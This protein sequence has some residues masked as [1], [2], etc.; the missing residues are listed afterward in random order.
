MASTKIRGITIEL[1]A[2]T[3]GLTKAL[4]NT[5]KE[6][7]ST[8][9]QLKDVERLLKLDP[10]NTE[11]LEQK[12]RLLGQSVEQTRDKL[13]ALKEAQKQVA[14][15]L[16]RTGEGQEQYD[17]L[18][19]EIIQTEA[20]LKKAESAAK[21]FNTTTAKISATADKVAGKFGTLANKTRA[22]SMAAGGALVAL[23][24]LAIKAGKDADELNTLAK[25]TG[26]TTEE[27][28]KMQYAS[29]LIDVDVSTITGAL[30]KMKK[31]LESNTDAFEALGVAV[32]ENGQ[33]RD[34]TDI[35]YDTVDALSKIPNETE[36]DI[37]AMEIFGKSADELAGIID[38]GGEALRS[39]GAEAAN[40]GLI[41]PQ[42]DIDKANEL[43]DAID[44]LKAQATA[45][46]T[47]IGTTIAE[48]ILPYLPTI[49]EKIQGILEAL[50]EVDPKVI[51]ITGSVLALAAV[52][53]PLFSVISGI[54]KTV[55]LL[56]TGISGLAGALGVT[57]GALSAV[58]AGAAALGGI[59]ATLW[60]T[61]SE[62]KDKMVGTWDTIRGKF[63][64]FSNGIF[65]RLQAL[66][67][68]I[69]SWGDIVKSIWEDICNFFAP[70]FEDV[71]TLISD[72][73]GGVLDTLT[74]LFDIFA[75]LFTGNWE[76]M[77]NGI[78][79]FFGG[80]W[81]T[82]IGVL[83][84]AVNI[85]IDVIN[86]II[87]GINKIS[88]MGYSPNIPTIPRLA[89]GGVLTSGT[90]IVGEAGPELVQV[91]EGRAM[92]QPLGSG[93]DLTDLLRTYLPYLAAGT[94]MVMDSGALVGSIAPDMN[95]A[96][97]TIAIRGGRR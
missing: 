77:W 74:G 26:V 67:F 60:N 34:I 46:L 20:D 44:T 50:R 7:S 38:D 21:S 40:L 80:I 53:S 76:Q 89:E 88:F 18:Q 66:G 35:F 65:E 92:V 47:E 17:A 82:I 57:V 23:G 22:I 6:I 94:T 28:Q 31:G 36:R 5:N 97:G 64:E 79:E 39:L 15:E 41:I 42:E 87:G 4:K 51:A 56:S 10:T 71:W 37:K 48:M 45:S 3:S 32:K 54:A 72:I 86:G 62:F 55:S 19:R 75:G 73:F 68:N 95:V 52:L 78:K 84:G 63:D 2:D 24:G 61:N 27:L 25:Q 83:K 58:A 91:S 16:E 8:Q 70:I 29:D 69:Q 1:G 14:E 11:L 13:D 90:A 43:N 59:F 93:S 9:K 49:Q 85:I 81:D 30:K 96:L 12:Q 33:F